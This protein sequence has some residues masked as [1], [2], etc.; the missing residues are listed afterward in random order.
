MD[1]QRPASV[2]SG[3]AGMSIS[4]ATVPDDDGWF[5]A[6][7]D[8]ARAFFRARGRLKTY[9]AGNRVYATDDPPDALYRVVSGEVRL[10]NY[11]VPGRE[12]LNLVARAGDW[13]GELSIIDRKPRPHDAVC[14]GAATLFV[15]P[16]AV[17]E[18]YAR[19]DAAIY[20]RIAL[21]ACAHQRAALAF[22]ANSLSKGRRARLAERLLAWQRDAD[23][24]LHV[25]QDELAAQVGSSRQ[26]LNAMLAELRRAGIIATA[27]GRIAVLDAARLA[28]MAD[29]DEG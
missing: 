7:P 1:S 6:L 23:G 5:G 21:I 18:D 16:L 4:S 14:A 17:I 15:V 25:R 26:R 2:R 20:G 10:V 22:I 8:A 11:P 3:R 24:T 29:G 13:F 19:E 28:V 27:Y 9:R 12:L